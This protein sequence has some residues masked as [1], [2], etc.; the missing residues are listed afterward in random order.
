MVIQITTI[1]F[2]LNLLNEYLYNLYKMNNL[3]NVTSS[4][5]FIIFNE[6]YIFFFIKNFIISKNVIQF[7]L[8]E[9]S[10]TR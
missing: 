6:H 1:L 10:L 4:I 8:M 5:I 3:S 9:Y 7:I 2:F